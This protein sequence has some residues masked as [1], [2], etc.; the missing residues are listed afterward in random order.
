ME[1]KVQITSHNYNVISD[2]SIA[3]ISTYRLITVRINFYNINIQVFWDMTPYMVAFR[4]FSEQL[5][6]CIFTLYV[7]TLLGLLSH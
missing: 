2:I 1:L 6:A 4:E 3:T 5:V 7:V